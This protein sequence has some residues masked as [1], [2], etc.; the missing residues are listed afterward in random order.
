MFAP[1][2]K[3]AVRVGLVAV[4]TAAILVLFTQ[5][6]IPGLNFSGVSGGL[7]T[8]LAIVYHWCPGAQIVFPVAITMMTVYLAIMVFQFAMI[9]VRWIFK[10]NE[11]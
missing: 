6:Q 7:N 8:A 1:A 4:V 9:A 3:M 2:I 10:V 11:G 5:V